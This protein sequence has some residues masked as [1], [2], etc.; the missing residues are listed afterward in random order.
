[1][2][3]YQGFKSWLQSWLHLA[4]DALHVHV[5]LAVFL[6]AALLFRWPLKSWK[7]WLA[8]AAAAVAGEVWDL[9]DTLVRDAPL[10]L[11]GQAKDLVSTVL[12]PTVLM[13]LARHTRVFKRS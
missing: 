7:P 6:G 1:M 10:H 8:V 3:G 2:S 9:R 4:K 11:A 13:L 12:W 5:G